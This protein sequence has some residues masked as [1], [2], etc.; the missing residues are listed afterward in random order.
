METSYD[1]IIVGAG[2]A[3]SVVAARLA[4]NPAITV[5]LIEAGSTDDGNWEVLSVKNCQICQV[6]LEKTPTIHPLSLAFLEAAQQGRSALFCSSG[7][8]LSCASSWDRAH[9]V[10]M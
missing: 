8:P 9:D 4:E 7:T 1:Y 10:Y 3:G 6:P 2:T 5:C